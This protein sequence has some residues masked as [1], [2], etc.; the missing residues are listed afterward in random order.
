MATQNFQVLDSD[1]FL[2]VEG[3][4]LNKTGTYSKEVKHPSLCSDLLRSSY[5]VILDISTCLFYLVWKNS[6][7]F[8]ITHFHVNQNKTIFIC[9]DFWT[10]WSV[11][12]LL[13][14]L[15]MF[16]ITLHWDIF[17][18]LL[19]LEVRL[20]QIFFNDFGVEI[21]SQGFAGI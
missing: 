16:F 8:Y 21:V 10:C 1:Q 15:E 11:M 20:L 7:T 5:S 18:Y 17:S 14:L 3:N 6:N 2:L 4:L 9:Y 13:A 19:T 12:S